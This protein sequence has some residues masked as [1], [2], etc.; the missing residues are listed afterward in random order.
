MMKTVQRLLEALKAGREPLS[1]A[2]I[3]P[4][5]L[6]SP[7]MNA[8]LSSSFCTGSIEIK[9]ANHCYLNGRQH[10]CKTNHMLLCQAEARGSVLIIL[11][12]GSGT[13]KWPVNSSTLT[14][15][16]EA[17]ASSKRQKMAEK[18]R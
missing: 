1:V 4:M 11:Q 12:N 13:Q 8:A 16:E 17:F 2:L 10:C 7:A 5:W 15:L 6:G 14:S 3:L 9:G 18:K